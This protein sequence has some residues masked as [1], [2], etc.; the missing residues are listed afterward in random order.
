MMRRIIVFL[1]L[2]GFGSCALAL[3][4]FV[5][6]IPVSRGLIARWDIE[7]GTGTTS[8]RDETGNGYTATLTSIS[9]GDWG[10]GPI[11]SR[12]W[13]DTSSAGGYLEVADAD[14]FSFTDGSTTNYPFSAEVCAKPGS[15]GSKALM[16][17]WISSNHEWLF[18]FSASKLQ[19][20]IG[21]SSLIEKA[22]DATSSGTLHSYGFSYDGDQTVVLYMDGAPIASTT[23]GTAGIFSNLGAPVAIGTYNGSTSGSI[24]GPIAFA[25]LYSVELTQEEHAAIAQECRE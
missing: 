25:Q 16:S 2:I 7:E 19:L 23:T 6:D 22:D 4:Q 8:T 17:K 10:S 18:W 24:I 20:Y 21:G 15:V 13:L 1:A 5:Q 14:I 9:E 3:S 11:S 12:Y